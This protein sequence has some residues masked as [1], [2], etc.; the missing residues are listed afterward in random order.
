MDR[1]RHR[2]PARTV[3]RRHRVVFVHRRMTAA[4]RH[5]HHE[6]PC[7]ILAP[8]SSCTAGH[9]SARVGNQGPHSS[10][11]NTTTNLGVPHPS[12][13]LIVRWVGIHKPNPAISIHPRDHG[14]LGFD[15]P[16]ELSSHLHESWETSP[17]SR[18]S[19]SFC[20]LQ[21]NAQPNR[22]FRVL[23]IGLSLLDLGEN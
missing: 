6:S 12:D 3:G 5:H 13:S 18:V 9:S 19:D 2:H 11:L 8:T 16:A 22:L 7:P 1:A 10:L 14:H 15:A 23:Y 21:L 20:A 17:A 4:F